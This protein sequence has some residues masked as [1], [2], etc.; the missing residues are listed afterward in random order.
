MPESTGKKI[1]EKAEAV[2]SDDEEMFS[3]QPEDVCYILFLT[4]VLIVSSSSHAPL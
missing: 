2:V 1:T 3:I 4:Y